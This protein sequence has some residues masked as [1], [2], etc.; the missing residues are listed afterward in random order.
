MHNK[1]N[2]VSMGGNIE[3]TFV[4][5]DIFEKLE[6]IYSAWW[7]PQKQASNSTLNGGLV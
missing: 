7:S 4:T 3:C 2:N 6:C 1:I 5:L